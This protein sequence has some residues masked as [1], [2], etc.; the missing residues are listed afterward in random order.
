M[1][2]YFYDS[3]T[4]R[5]KYPKTFHDGQP[6][7]RDSYQE[8][9]PPATAAGSTEAPA[10]KLA[11]GKGVGSGNGGKTLGKLRGKAGLPFGRNPKD[12]ASKKSAVSPHKKL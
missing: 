5:V 11:L 1:K 10:M 7:S 4:Y 8:E 9:A 6:Q 2:K 3:C 12:K